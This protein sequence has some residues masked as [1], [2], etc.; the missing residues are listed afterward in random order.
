MYQKVCLDFGADRPWYSFTYQAYKFNL[1]K[2]I[3]NAQGEEYYLPW[4]IIT[5]IQ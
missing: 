1:Y 2:I 3:L 4:R 5:T